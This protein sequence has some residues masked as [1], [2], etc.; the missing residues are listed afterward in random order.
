MMPN[1]DVSSL[2]STDQGSTGPPVESLFTGGCGD[3]LGGGS[4]D[5]LGDEQ[6]H[7]FSARTCI[8]LL[9]HLSEAQIDTEIQH[10]RALHPNVKFRTR[11]PSNLEVKRDLL[12]KTL[13]NSI[14]Q[15]IDCIVN[16]FD[17]LVN[18]ISR[19]I[20]VAQ[21]HVVDVELLLSPTVQP[22]DITLSQPIISGNIDLENP[23]SFL[24]FSFPE[25][26]F[27][28]I[29]KSINFTDKQSGDRETAYFGGIG[30]SYDQVSHEPADYPTTPLFDTLFAKLQ[31]FD[32]ECTRD[33]FTCLVTRY[34]DGNSSLNLHHDDERCILPG[35][36]IYTVSFG[37]TRSVKFS[38]IKGPLNEQVHRLEHGSVHCMTKE[39]QSVWRHGILREPE[40]TGSRISF[41]FRQLIDA[42]K[43]AKS[44]IPPIAPNVPK[45][46]DKQTRVL[47]L[48]DS[49][50]SS[51][52]N[53]IFNTLPN[54][55]CIKKL[56]FQLT[57]VH[58]FRDEF[59]YTD[60]VIVSCGVNDLSRYGHT[61][62]SL[63]DVV[64]RRFKQYSEQFPNTKFIFNT[65]LLSRDHKWLNTEIIS[66][67]KYMYDLSRRTPN[68]YFFNS[69]GLVAQSNIRRVYPNHPNNNGI[70]VTLDVKKLVTR[71]LVNS[72]GF[73]AGSRGARFQSCGWLCHVTNRSSWAG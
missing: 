63:A 49:V 2:Q 17:L 37:A 41:T 9:P 70:H 48:T 4:R 42:P 66:F 68:L 69:D 27:D 51:T 72:V 65:I 52:P 36:N 33:N 1:S 43:V 18:N 47:F 55:V 7:T 35:S 67:N 71:E 58:S 34:P 60:V 23:V 12:H 57:D 24:D 31:T 3:G 22:E 59:D 29:E 13:A 38:N 19:S 5:I 14:C 11:N 28:D 6:I 46:V 73:I 54:H 56:N 15:E 45:P 26:N 25:I 16:N 64:C 50:L 20:K 8:E 21:Q 30:Y 62:N 40:V 61:A 44:D 32:S 39:S 53:F 10:L